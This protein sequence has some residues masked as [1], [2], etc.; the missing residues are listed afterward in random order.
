MVDKISR[1]ETE[2]LA[3]RRVHV[4]G[5]VNIVDLSAEVGLACTEE[6]TASHP[7]DVSVL[8]EVGSGRPLSSPA[9]EPDHL[10]TTS[11]VVDD[12]SGG[13]AGEGTTRSVLG[14]LPGGSAVDNLGRVV[15]HVL[16]AHGG[17]SLDVGS[18]E[19]GAVGKADQL[20]DIGR[21]ATNTLIGSGGTERWLRVGIDTNEA[22]TKGSL[23]SVDGVVLIGADT[24]VPDAAIVLV[25]KLAERDDTTI[26]TLSGGSVQGRELVAS[27]GDVGN[28]V[29]DSVAV[30]TRCET[31]RV[32]ASPDE[33]KDG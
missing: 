17:T 21:A 5:K 33:K 12:S 24:A 3:S 30:K 11:E 27:L 26:F 25:R 31:V 18:R 19:T 6:E 32:V 23:V 7:V 16:G 10:L 1:P 15:V 8:E 29:R 4:G 2:A 13:V 28:L 14:N 20:L 9:A 22:N